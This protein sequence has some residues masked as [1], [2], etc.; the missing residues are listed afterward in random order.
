MDSELHQVAYLRGQ[1]S[2]AL[3]EDNWGAIACFVVHGAAKMDSGCD[4]EPRR[5]RLVEIL[6]RAPYL[7]WALLVALI[8]LGA[9]ALLSLEAG[10][11]S[12][13]RL[14]CAHPW[15]PLQVLGVAIYAWGIKTVLTKL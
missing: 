8:S 12:L 1:H 2:A 14:A 5:N 6:G 15:M 7:V 4:V 11:T 10:S 13:V 9:W 3:I